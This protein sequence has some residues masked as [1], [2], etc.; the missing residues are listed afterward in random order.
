VAAERQRPRRS[1]RETE[2][3]GNVF[4][5]A[6]DVPSTRTSGGR[7]RRRIAL[8]AAALTATLA[9]PGAAQADWFFSKSGAERATKDYVADRYAD[10]YAGDLTT[11]CRPQGRAYDPGYKYH[12]WVCG[13]YDESD[14]TSG[15]VLIV[16]S[17]SSGAYYGRVL[18]RAH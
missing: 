13:W 6:G 11:S 17:S 9:L 18:I 8:G 2:E 15:A 3:G 7:T 12:R 1:K 16:G 5:H 14:D 10:T 4:T